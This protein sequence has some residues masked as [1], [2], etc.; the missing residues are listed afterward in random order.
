MLLYNLFSVNER[1][2]IID[3][4]KMKKSPIDHFLGLGFVLKAATLN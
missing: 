2:Q 1:I 3:I 4:K